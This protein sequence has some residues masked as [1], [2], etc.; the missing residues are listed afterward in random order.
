MLADLAALTELDVSGNRLSTLPEGVVA[1]PTALRV[2][3]LS[4]NRLVVDLDGAF[5]AAPALEELDLSGNRIDA[6]ADGVFEELTALTDLDLSGNPGAPFAPT[7]DA[8]PDD[9]TV[10]TAGGDV[11]ADRQRQRRGVGRQRDLWLGADRPGE[12][13]DIRRG[14]VRR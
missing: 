5:L 3:D 14:D 6:L 7:A 11:A 8:L 1:G 2:L 13:D 12:W 4:D 10:P 9:A